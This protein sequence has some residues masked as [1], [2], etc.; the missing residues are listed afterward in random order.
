MSAVLDAFHGLTVHEF[1]AVPTITENHAAEVF[2]DQ[3]C[4]YCILSLLDDDISLLRASAVCKQWKAVVDLDSVWQAV[5]R[6]MLP[7][8]LEFERVNRCSA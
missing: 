6:R 3:A 7:Q 8:P 2:H 4:L 1:A 5:Y